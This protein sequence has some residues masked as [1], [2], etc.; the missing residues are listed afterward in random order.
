MTRHTLRIQ[1][2]L[3]DANIKLCGLVSNILGVRGRA[4]LEAI[5]AGESSPETL[6]AV[7]KGRLKAS[8]ESLEAAALGTTRD[9][10]RFL[11]QVQ[12]KQIDELETAITSVEAHIETV[13]QPFRDL[14]EFVSMLSAA[15]LS[16]LGRA[17]LLMAEG[18]N[19]AEIARRYEFR[20]FR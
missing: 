4:M 16:R 12:L 2:I 13:V 17:I 20:R 3:E 5:I 11:L 9:H 8:R 15:G 7:T 1:K 19:G 18:V 10:H 6:V 14:K